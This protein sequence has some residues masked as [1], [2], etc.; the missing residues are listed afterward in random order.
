MNNGDDMTDKNQ[1]KDNVVSLAAKREE[2]ANAPAAET[3][4]APPPDKDF[5]FEDIMKA[6]KEK[7][8]KLKLEREKANKSVKRSYRLTPKK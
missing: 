4:S 1:G 3:P 8:E 7:E 5:S 6:N 2:K